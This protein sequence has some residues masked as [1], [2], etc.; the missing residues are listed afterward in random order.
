MNRT[1]SREEFLA[2]GGAHPRARAACRAAH[3]AHRGLPGRDRGAVR[4]P[5]LLRRGGAVRLRGRVRLLAARRARRAVRPAR[6]AGR[7]RE[8]RPCP[9]PARPGRRRRACPR[10]AARVGQRDGRAGGG[11]RRG[12]P[13]VRARHVPGARGRRRRVPRR[14]R[15]G[16]RSAACASSTLCSTR[17]KGSCS[18]SRR[19]RCRAREAVDPGE[20]RDACCASA[21]VPV[22]VVAIIS[23]WPAC[24]PLSGA[25]AEASK[26]WIAAGIFVLLAATDGLDGYLARSRGEV[27]NF[28][29][30]IDPLADKILVA[31]ALLALV[32]LSRP[33]LV[34]GARHPHARVHRVRASAWWPPAKAWSLPPAGTARRRPSTQIVAIVLFIIKDSV[35]ITDP[36]GVLHNPLVP[37]VVGRHDRGA[38]ADHRCRCSTTSSRRAEILGLAL[39]G[40]SREAPYRCRRGRGCRCGRGRSGWTCVSAQ[41]AASISP[42]RSTSWSAACA[43]RHVPPAR[44]SATAESLTGGMVA[45]DAHRRCPA[46]PPS[47]GAASSATCDDVKRAVLGVDRGT[48]AWSGRAR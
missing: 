22:F 7:G 4:G 20:R 41:V 3:D 45:A 17:W 10:I 47:C 1:G 25:D 11:R 6:P 44:R 2:L 46:A 14:R 39:S 32:E 36:E 43:R 9:A 15:A 28:G 37:G 26:P 27:T 21:C 34:G 23:P 40:K 16:R 38:G 19:Q 33:A 5:V 18:P 13:A 8:E 31:A 12:R 30:F 24:F 29:K 42:R 35:V 48:L